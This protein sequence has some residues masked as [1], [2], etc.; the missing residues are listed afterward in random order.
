MRGAS[1]TTLTSRWAIRPPR[2]AHAL[3]REGEKTVGGSAAPLRIAGREMHPDIAVGERAENGVDQRMQR[4]I[5]VG[6]P[7]EALLM[8]NAH[9][10][11]RDMVAGPEGVHVVARIRCARR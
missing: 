6:M 4:H 10:A 7:G 2:A 11:E 1:Q 3:D 8:R 5:G 9:A